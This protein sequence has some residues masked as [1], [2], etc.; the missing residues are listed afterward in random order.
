MNF[1]LEY[2]AKKGAFWHNV[3]NIHKENT[4]GYITIAKDVN[5]YEY[6][7]FI[8][9]LGYEATTLVFPYSHEYIKLQW[10]RFQKF[11]NLLKSRKREIS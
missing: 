6:N 10:R 2:N 4:N 5:S 3:N 1:I 8:N 9:Y 7:D 11:K